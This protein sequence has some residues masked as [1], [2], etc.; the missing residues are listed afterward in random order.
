MRPARLTAL[1]FAIALTASGCSLL[2]GGDNSSGPPATAGGPEKTHIVIASLPTSD[3]VPLHLAIEDGYFKDAGLEV[4]L[5]AGASGQDNVTKLVAGEVDFA[6]SSYTPFF[7][8]QAKKVA[9][10]K[11]VA[12]ATACSPNYS[13]VYAMPDSPVQHL[14]DIG[15]KRVAIT[16][17]LTMTEFLLDGVAKPA[18]I[19][20]KSIQ[21]A[22]M[23]FPKMKDALL[24]HQVDAAY[25]VEPFGT[26]AADSGAVPIFD[27][28]PE[29]GPT[30]R[31]PLT[32]YGA[33]ADFVAKNKRTVEAFQRVLKRATD[34]A[35]QDDVRVWHLIEKYAKV[36]LSVAQRAKLPAFQSSL[37]PVRIQRVVDLM[38][39]FGG[40]A[41]RFDVATMIVRPPAA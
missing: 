35:S 38:V 16:A 24:K 7:A 32:G 8:A 12:D 11:L 34:A 25:I 27:T 36:A 40:L 29:S 6:Y 19:D 20:L 23:G 26:D 5:R 13:M 17:K 22:E 41:S 18:G 10:L 21:F 2:G 37:D 1:A 39:E 33:R 4:E 30:A 28:A 3:Q 14:G 15:G 9:D 31:M